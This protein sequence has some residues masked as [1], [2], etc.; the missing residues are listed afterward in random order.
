MKKLYSLTLF[1]LLLILGLS[2]CQSN[3]STEPETLPA[4]KD[5]SGQTPAST[6]EPADTADLQE[7]INQYETP[8]RVVWQK[9]EM[10]INKMGDLSNKV[11]ADLGAGSGYFARR[12]A[13]QAKKV[14]ALEVDE[15][16]IH[17]MDSIKLVELKPEYQKRF[18]TRLVTPDDP[19]LKQGEVD[20]VLIVNTY[21]YLENRIEYMQRFLSLLPKG[22]QVIIVDFKKKRMPIKYPPV[23]KRLELF[24]VENELDAA[25]F[26]RIMS[27]DQSLDYQYIV[28]AEK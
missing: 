20:I 14:I 25:G 13:Q 17:F 6:S 21:I 15:R 10:V 3:Q 18:E 22:G 7:L 9:P 5:T 12:L 27:D 19:K 11:V 16:W 4:P 1:S 8:G 28:V 24:E 2:A 23:K 26:S